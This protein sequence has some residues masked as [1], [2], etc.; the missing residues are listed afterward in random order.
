MVESSTVLRIGVVGCGKIA[1][2]HIN[3]YRKFPNVEVTVTDVVKDGRRTAEEYSVKWHAD[4]DELIRGELVDAIDVCT[5]TSAHAEVIISAMENGKDV[6]CEKPLANTLQEAEHIQETA[7]KT[8]RILMVG[9]LY[10]FHPAF[11]FVRQVLEERV[12]GEVYYAM[13]RVGGRGSHKVWKHMRGAGGG[14]INEML[15]HMLDLALWYFG[16]ASSACSLYEETI[17]KEREIEGKKVQTD[18]EDIVLVCLNMEK[19]TKV[20]CE[21]DLITPSYMNYVEIQGTNGSI[22]T[23][24][25]DYFPTVI[26]CK[27]PRGVYDRGHN[28]FRFG[29]VDLFEAE[30]SHFVQCALEK[31]TPDLNSIEDSIRLMSLL[32]EVKSKGE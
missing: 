6:F 20:F 22:W 13:F 14:A 18:A 3:A 1:E 5:P 7:Q 9:Y 25:L 15:V 32:E 17:L 24:I 23:S 8:G 27:E 30:L 4:T 26:Y 29:R 10:R 21:S 12:I 11:Q 31:Q 28:F 2:R 16:E 19:G